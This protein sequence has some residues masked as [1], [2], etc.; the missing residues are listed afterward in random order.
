MLARGDLALEADIRSDTA[1]L[2]GLVDALLARRA[3]ARAGCAIRPAAA[4]APSCNELARDTGLGGRARRGGAARAARPSTARATCSASTRCTSPTRARS[5]PSCPPTRPTP[6]CAALRAPPARCRRR[7][8]RRDRGRARR[9]RRAAHHVR[10][11]PH[12]RHAR[13]RP[14]A[15]D[16]LRDCAWRA[17]CSASPARCRA[18]GSG[19]SCTGTRSRSGSS[20]SVCN[21]SAGVLIDVE[22]DADRIAELDTACS[23]DE[24]PPL[25]RVDA[26]TVE[27][28]GPARRRATASASSR[29]T[30]PA[31]RRTRSSVD[32]ATCAECLAEVDDPADRRYRYPFTN[33][34]NCGPR[35]TIVLSVPYDRP[36]TTMAGFAMCA[37]CRAE[38]D[39]PA[40]RRFHA[41]PNACPA[42]G[43]QLAWRDARRRRSRPATPRSTPRS[44]RCAAARSSRSRAS[45][46]T[47]SRSTPPTTA[48][49]GELRRRKARDD[50]PF[51]VMVRDLDAARHAV[52]ARRR[53]RRRA[54]LA[55]TADRARAPTRRRA[56]RRRCGRARARPSSACS[57]RT[58][59]CTTCS[60]RGVGRPLVMTSGNLQRRADRP[61]RRRRRRP[62][63]APL[64][65]G[66]LTH[67]RPIHIRCDDSVARATGGRL[68]LLRRSRGYAP[69]PMRLP[70]ARR[71]HVL[72]VGAELKSD[73]RGDARARR[74][75]QPPHRRP[76]APRD[77]P[78]VPAGRRPPA[79]ALRRASRGRRP[80]PAPGVPV[81]EVRASTSTFPPS[82]C[83]TTTRTSPRAWSEHGA[84]GAGARRS[85]STASA[86]GPTARSGAARS[87]VADLD[88]FE[89]VGHLRPVADAGRCGGDPRAVAHG[90]GVGAAGGRRRSTRASDGSTPRRSTRCSTSPQRPRA[91]DDEHGPAVR[92][93]RRAP[94][95]PDARSATRPR[96]PSSSRRWRAAVDRARRAR[97]S[98]ARWP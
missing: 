41:Q 33:C 37:A 12:R 14:A 91:D 36:A 87:C 80:R 13:R 27:A 94:R 7:R 17:R 49:V 83:S 57:C 24:P 16:L 4:S 39:D 56:D 18:S 55:A 38:Y 64:V 48:A 40:D 96:P 63:S 78:V 65:D 11:H 2:G 43:P 54:R 45:A 70:F 82:R 10:R 1:P 88:G 44:T 72:A 95:R 20:G 15:A 98:T 52:R 61:R 30:R 23:T 75:R 26:V 74:R 32:T 81:D 51:A 34:T 85:R 28:A 68:Q 79:R 62:G 31:R 29:A 76:R 25:A 69:E 71:A 73:D 21:D 66:L 93:G 9:H 46:A 97:L 60:S 3:R 53:R 90:G 84:H 5:S 35:Y 6:R 67:D 8:D 86:T 22:G 47:T 50:K 92:R 77:V 42:C 19:R 89:R 58:R 59:R